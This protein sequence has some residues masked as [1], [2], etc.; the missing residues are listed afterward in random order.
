MDKVYSRAYLQGIQEERK[1]QTIDKMVHEFIHELIALSARGETSY[2]F[3]VVHQAPV[4]HNGT[5]GAQLQVLS[6]RHGNVP[7]NI[8]IDDLVAGFQRKFPDCKVSYNESWIEQSPTSRY[9]NK[10]IVIDWS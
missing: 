5:N 10:A 2:R 1:K 4:I 8:S 3:P 7:A 6:M 9:L